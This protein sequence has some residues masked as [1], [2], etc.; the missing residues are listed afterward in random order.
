MSEHRHPDYDTL[1]KVIREMYTPKEY[2]YLPDELK[3]TLIEDETTPDVDD[4][5]WEPAL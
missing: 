3:R 1:P 4:D 2:V 5:E